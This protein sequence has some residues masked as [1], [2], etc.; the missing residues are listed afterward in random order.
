MNAESIQSDLSNAGLVLLFAPV[1]GDLHALDRLLAEL[2]LE[3]VICSS[4]QQFYDRIGEDVLL[5]VVTEQALVSCRAEELENVLRSQPQWSDMPLLAL[6]DSEGGRVD[7]GRFDRLASIGNFML[8]ETPT[9]RQVLLMSVRAAIRA[10]RL[11]YAVRDHWHELES[12]AGRLEAAVQERTL[13]LEHEV[14]ERSRIQAELDE[15]RRLESLGRLTGGVAHDFNNLLQVI[16]GGE[17]LIRLLQGGRL[18][19]QMERALDSIRRAADHGASLTQRLLA[20][21]RRQPL[22]A[23]TLDLSSHLAAT[24]DLLLRTLECRIDFQLR[25]PPDL[26]AVDADPAQLDAAILNIVGNACDAMPEGGTLT[27]AA[28]NVN[29][30]APELPEARQ[31]K[32]DYVCL[33]M[34][35]SGEGMS[36]QVADHAFEPFFTTKSAGRGTGL[37]LSQVYGFAIQSG[38]LAFIRREAIGTTIGLLLPRSAAVVAVAPAPVVPSASAGLED[39]RMLCV[40]DDPAVASTTGELLRSLGASVV[41]ADSADAAMKLDLSQFDVV[42]SDV[43]MPGS[44]DGI[45]FTRWLSEFHPSLPVVLCSG[46]ML[47]PHRL[48]SLKAEFVRK[49]YRIADLIAS[50]G[51]AVAFSP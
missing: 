40:E 29:L 46:Y 2:G 51:R 50:I 49:P 3:I 47:D 6:V 48:Q 42:L 43:M 14:Q 17:T 45:E 27:M 39:I 18:A 44:M 10:R 11:Q 24:A 41:V 22:S 36:E 31:L 23:V 30:P 38:G 16:T 7:S 35:D 32:G 4:P 37:G 26:W 5:A 13:E 28:H 25:L 21:A 9:S 15:A 20:Y 12:H 34:S 8:L 19:P 33:M 1:Q